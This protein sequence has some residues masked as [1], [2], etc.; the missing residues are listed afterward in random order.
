M[1]RYDEYKP[2][3]NLDRIWELMYTLTKEHFDMGPPGDLQFPN[4]WPD[5]AQLPGFRSFLES[6]FDRFE[7][8]TRSILEAL[9]V[10]LGLEL[11][12]FNDLCTHESN[13]SEFRLLHYKSI[14]VADMKRRNRIS[15]HFD[16]G[17]IT[18]LFQDNVGGL[19]MENRKNPGTFLPVEPSSP[20][21]MVVNIA[22][23][24]QRWTNNTLRAGLH[25][26]TLPGMM[27]DVDTI[28]ERYSITY[29]SKADRSVSVAPLAPFV[30]SEKAPV[31]DDM[32]ALEY[33]QQ[34]V[35]AA[36]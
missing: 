19:E 17:V 1:R 24:F 14:S 15:P 4:K 32:T 27:G 34:R 35:L 36:Y 23:T 5:D 8:V 25:R 16:L 9:E 21:D 18:L 11:G 33:Q 7:T 2:V 22:E 29:F 3:Q 30:S 12:T 26:V 28:P 31:Y 6:C 13:G 20:A 10:G